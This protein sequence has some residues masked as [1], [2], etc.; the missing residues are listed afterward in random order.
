MTDILIR[1]VPDE[2]VAAIDADAGKLGISRT[3]FLRRALANSVSR[4][5]QTRLADLAWFEQ[6]FTDL[7][8]DDRMNEAW[9]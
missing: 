7:S 2:I 5:G 6:T 3:E 9:Q 4:S 1:D 8:D